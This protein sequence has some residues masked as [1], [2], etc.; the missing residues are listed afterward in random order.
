LRDITFRIADPYKIVQKKITDSFSKYTTLSEIYAYR[1]AKRSDLEAKHGGWQQYDIVKEY[2]RQGIDFVVEEKMEFQKKSKWRL[3]KN[4]KSSYESLCDSYP[5]YI[6]IPGNIS[7]INLNIAIKFRSKSRFPAM[8]Y[9]WIN[10]ELPNGYST[11]W[12]SAQCNVAFVSSRPGS[13][14]GPLRMSSIFSRCTI[15]PL[16]ERFLSTSKVVYDLV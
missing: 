7:P 3:V 14:G 8:T 12:R 1:F 11:L 13:L 16:L 9:Y 5:E 15:P 2:T 6:M 4:A 10:P